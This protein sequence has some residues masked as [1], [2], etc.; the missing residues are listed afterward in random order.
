MRPIGI[1]LTRTFRLATRRRSSLKLG[2]LGRLSAGRDDL[3]SV[4]ALAE[5]LDLAAALLKDEVERERGGREDMLDGE[6]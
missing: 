1:A 5:A 3:E 2:C 4:P 6:V